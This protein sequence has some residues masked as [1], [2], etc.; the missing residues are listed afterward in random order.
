MRQV[1]G[2]ESTLQER[3]TIWAEGLV[4][5]IDFCNHGNL[6]ALDDR[7][8]IHLAHSEFYTWKVV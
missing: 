8:L 3:E 4:P 6:N 7:F 2:V 5:G 1:S